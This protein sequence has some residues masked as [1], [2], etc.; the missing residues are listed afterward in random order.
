MCRKLSTLDKTLGHDY[1]INDNIEL[2]KFRISQKML[3]IDVT[4]IDLWDD[5]HS[6]GNPTGEY[7]IKYGCNKRIIR[8][9]QLSLN[10]V[11]T[12]EDRI[13]NKLRIMKL[14]CNRRIA[15]MFP[16]I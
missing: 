7:L 15:I 6:I 16:E 8:R 2:I 3:N 1:T 5:L 13:M 9:Q 10:C 14:P 4:K 11:M 12:D